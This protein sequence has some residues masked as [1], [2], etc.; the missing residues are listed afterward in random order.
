MPQSNWAPSLDF[1]WGDGSISHNLLSW[2]ETS[3]Y[4]VVVLVLWRV[5]GFGVQTR[6]VSQ[7]RGVGGFVVGSRESR[8]SWR[9]DTVTG[10]R[11]SNV[12]IT[13]RPFRQV[14][15]NSSAK[16]ESSVIIYSPPSWWKG[17]WSFLALKIFLEVH[18]ETT[19]CSIVQTVQLVRGNLSLWE[20][21][22][23]KIDLKRHLYTRLKFRRD[24]CWQHF[25]LATIVNIL[26]L[27]GS[28]QHLFESIRISGWGWGAN[29]WMFIFGWNCCFK[30]GVLGY[31]TGQC[32]GFSTWHRPLMQVSGVRIW[33]PP[34]AQHR[35]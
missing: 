15:K 29:T 13:G 28:I 24:E 5:E 11:W 8:N 16:N 14:E 7:C 6:N 21:R 2:A 30:Q 3:H 18:S 34:E 31:H 26:A 23:P 19:D 32:E 35:L 9:H 10:G 27:K 33:I 20:P 1:Y 25:S 12:V 17:R 4:C 22:D